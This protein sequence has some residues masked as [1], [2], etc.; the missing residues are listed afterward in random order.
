[1]GISLGGGPGISGERTGEEGRRGEE[2]NSNL[3]AWLI[4]ITTGARQVSFHGHLGS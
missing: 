3:G 1:M 4:L 2:N